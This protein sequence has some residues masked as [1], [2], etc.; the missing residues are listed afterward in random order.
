MVLVLGN[1]NTILV[2]FAWSKIADDDIDDQIYA[3]NKFFFCPVL[4]S[5]SWP[6][7]W[8]F[9][10]V[11]NRSVNVIMYAEPKARRDS[12]SEL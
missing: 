9:P 4:L 1:Y 8:L 6:N 11:M 10:S 5:S 2:S 12:I 3:K 7:P